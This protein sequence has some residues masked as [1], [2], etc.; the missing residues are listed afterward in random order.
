MGDCRGGGKTSKHDVTAFLRFMWPAEAITLLATALVMVAQNLARCRSPF[1]F[2]WPGRCLPLIAFYVSLRRVED[3]EELAPKD[4]RTARIVARR[5]WRF[6]ETFVGEEDHWLPPDNFQEDPPVIAHRTSPTNIGL[7]QLS[8]LAAYDF[9]YLGLVELLERTELT[10]ASL[11]KL[12]KFRGHFFNWHDTRTLL[13]MWP[14]YVSVVD[15][16]NLVRLSN[17]PQAG[18]ALDLPDDK[19]FDTR[20]INGMRDTL[21]GVIQETSQLAA[22]RQRT[23]AITIKQLGDEIQLCGNLLAADAPLDLA[24]WRLLFES[25]SATSTVIDDI[26]AA[27]SL[28]HRGDEF[29]ELRWWTNSLVRQVHNYRRDLNLL[30]PWAVTGT[31]TLDSLA[32]SDEESRSPWEVITSELRGVP[33]LA[34]ISE[35]CDS[36]L[37]R[38]AALRARLE[39]SG[40][41]SLTGRAAALGELSAL[42]RAI[43]QGAESARTIGSRLAKIAQ[44]C[45]RLVDEMDFA[46]LL[47]SERK[48]FTIGYNVAEGHAD[49][50]FYDLLASEARL[51]SFVAI[52]K[53]DVPQEHWFRLGRQ[54]T[55]VDGGR[56]L[57][58]WTGTM[59]EYLMPLLVM[60]NYR[61]TLLDETYEA[62]VSRQ[63]EYGYE[64]GVPW[65]ISE[66]AYSARDL[67]LNYQ[68]GPF[69]VPGLGLKR[70]LDRRPGG[71]AL[72]DDAGGECVPGPAMENLRGWSEKARCRATVFTKRWITRRS[73]L[74]KGE[75]CT[76]VRAFMAHH[77]GMS[78]VALDNVLNAQ[79]HAK[80]ISRAIRR[81][82][83]RNCCLQERIPRGVP[84]AHP[85]AEEVLTGR[86]VRTLTGLVT[87]A[88][89]TAD[90]PTPRT[91]LLSNGTYSVMITTAGAGYSMC[92]PLAVTRWREDVNSRQLGQ[93]YLHPRRAQRR[94]L[95]SGSSTDRQQA[96]ELRSRLFG[97]QG[98]L[99]A[100]RLRHRHAHGGHRFGGRQRRDAAALDRELFDAPARN[101]IDQLCRS[102]A[103]A[104]G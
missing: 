43:E 39:A 14:Q 41:E 44:A 77:Q 83:R 45:H 104:P 92:G 54:L 30:V 55:A 88:Y 28:E 16:G 27:L 93:L 59:F 23:D 20:V 17:R 18:D 24:G 26:V 90:L 81:C 60:R 99:L 36:A 7:L 74:P 87:R 67:Q 47:D 71:C 70:G 32:L 95:V 1:P 12:Q 75:R 11:E 5:T 6:F 25:V 97:R 21:G 3:A 33:A 29:T 52:A 100:P 78:L 49:N 48:V 37:V 46:F 53:G 57:I 91:Q 98:R 2:C 38:L 58:S 35:I 4:V 15:S 80:S 86:V 10:F 56:A 66:S 8:T 42:T 89:D 34:H 22:A 68:Y 76:L 63:I 62:V 64:R 94:R 13:P 85:R 72:R 50:S 31:A 82:R 65:G 102:R 73:E 19:L 103:R 61:E 40:G 69:G 84:A 51:A 9:G 101:R 79:C 96:A